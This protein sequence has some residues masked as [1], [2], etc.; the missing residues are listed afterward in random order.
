MRGKKLGNT[1]TRMAET[2]MEQFSVRHLCGK[3]C[4]GETSV[5]CGS[6]RNN[7]CFKKKKIVGS[8]THVAPVATAVYSD[9]TASGRIEVP[10]NTCTHCLAKADESATSR[11]NV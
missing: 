6:G 4:R 11:W 5:R 8:Q 1:L 10:E 7:V 9:V 3:R 2:P